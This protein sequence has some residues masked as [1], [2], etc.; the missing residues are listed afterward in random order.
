MTDQNE[1]RINRLVFRAM[2]NL[3]MACSRYATATDTIHEVAERLTTQLKADEKVIAQS[4][5]KLG[6][7]QDRLRA[8][9]QEQIHLEYGRDDEISKVLNNSEEL[10]A[11][12]A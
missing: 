4:L 6:Q 2:R 10:R 7:I 3:L 8:V 1:A 12:P 5:E 9:R 11:I